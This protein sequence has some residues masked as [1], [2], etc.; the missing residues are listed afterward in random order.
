MDPKDIELAPHNPVRPD[1]PPW[2]RQGKEPPGG[3]DLPDAVTL[4][5][6]E[7]MWANLRAFAR[8]QATY[9]GTLIG[10]LQMLDARVTGELPPPPP[11]DTVFQGSGPDLAVAMPRPS[12]FR[13][14]ALAGQDLRGMEADIEDGQAGGS[15][16][17]YRLAVLRRF[18]AQ[19]R[20]ALGAEDAG[21]TPTSPSTGPGVFPAD[22]KWPAGTKSVRVDLSAT[23]ELVA[24]V[25]ARVPANVTLGEMEGLT[26]TLA[27]L[28]SDSWMAGD[29][30]VDAEGAVLEAVTDD[31]DC[32]PEALVIRGPDGSLTVFTADGTAL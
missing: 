9:L 24:L 20:A 12:L 31:P 8:E 21:P 14:H 28:A 29:E 15:S 6:P 7:T 13:L 32:R 23:G 10:D 18:D 26:G 4:T 1:P 22:A 19:V 17:Q 30:A 2:A 25:T 5:M 27:V 3:A 16:W 11:P